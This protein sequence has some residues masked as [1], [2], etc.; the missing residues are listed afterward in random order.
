[1]L[2]LLTS[3]L[4]D[5]SGKVGAMAF[6][7]HSGFDMALGFMGYCRSL[8]VYCL[9]C[10]C[11][12]F[13]NDLQNDEVSDVRHIMR[14]QHVPSCWWRSLRC[15]YFT[16]L[17]CFLC[18]ETSL[19]S[20]RS[21]HMCVHGCLSIIHLKFRVRRDV[22]DLWTRSIWRASRWRWKWGLL[23]S[24]T[25]DWWFGYSH[26]ASLH[27]EYDQLQEGCSTANI[28]PPKSVVERIRLAVLSVPVLSDLNVVYTRAEAI[29]ATLKTSNECIDGVKTQFAWKDAETI[30]NMAQA[31]V[32]EQ[33]LGYK[34]NLL[35]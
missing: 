3:S 10:T 18:Q 5:T 21:K 27:T 8:G 11:S 7:S 13:P 1:M 23:R 15:L 20:R 32:L 16:W 22:G 17:P 14:I 24:V 28:S 34:R 25:L 31:G 26:R 35:S 2:V 33:C 4:C 19:H 12:W 9:Q 29:A 6:L 30:A